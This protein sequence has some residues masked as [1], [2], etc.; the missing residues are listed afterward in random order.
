MKALMFLF[1]LGWNNNLQYADWFKIDA[2]QKRA[3]ADADQGIE[4]SLDRIERNQFHERAQRQADAD[5]IW[6]QQQ[7]MNNQIEFQQHQQRMQQQFNNQPIANP[8]RL[9]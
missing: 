6:V 1:I 7:Q 8:Y 5:R 3:S 2:Q 4:D 9:R